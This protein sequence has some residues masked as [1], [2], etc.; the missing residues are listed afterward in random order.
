[1][2]CEEARAQLSEVAG[3]ELDGARADEVRAHA[4]GCTACHAELAE[5]QATIALARRV[6]T[7]SL[8]EGFVMQL[9]QKLVEAGPPRRSFMMRVRQWLAERPVGLAL[10]AAALAVLVAVAGT[11]AALRTPAM[12]VA[13]VPEHKV[14]LVKIDFVAER[15]VDE[16][17]F[18]ITL[19]D[20]L[21]F[22]SGGQELAERS[23][24]WN[25][26]LMAGSN[27][28]PVAVKGPRAGRFRVIAH[29]TGAEHDVTHEVLLEV[30]S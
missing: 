9:H 5:L 22:Y 15:A 23:F 8:P 2:K 29:A 28:I 26:K 24:R 19:P 17:Q 13:R 30:T 3:G 25:G 21:R 27:P 11:R 4:R 14:A 18:E 20:G 12:A 7:L 6:G 10:G 1:M 16:V